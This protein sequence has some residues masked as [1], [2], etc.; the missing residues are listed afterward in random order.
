MFIPGNV[1]KSMGQGLEIAEMRIDSLRF[2]PPKR[3][4][5]VIGRQMPALMRDAGRKADKPLMLA[6]P[7]VQSAIAE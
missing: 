2:G 4:E 5:L 6:Y 1:R 3:E 7:A